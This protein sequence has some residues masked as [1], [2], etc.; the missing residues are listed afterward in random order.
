MEVG[1][2]I[3]RWIVV[4]WRSGLGW[5]ELLGVLGG[6]DGDGGKVVEDVAGGGG[7]WD[8][9]VMGL[10][11]GELE[12]PV[13]GFQGEF[14]VA[15]VGVV[16]CL[17]GLESGVV[18]VVEDLTGGAVSGFD[19]GCWGEGVD[20]RVEPVGPSVVV[21]WGFGDDDVEEVLGQV[22]GGAGTLQH[23]PDVV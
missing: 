5:S 21:A 15:S 1:F 9:V 8:G 18:V 7:I 23:V 12:F 17:D 10:D 6:V 16:A 4:V 2:T 19:F 13:S 20:E 3:G 22:F 14:G 11:G